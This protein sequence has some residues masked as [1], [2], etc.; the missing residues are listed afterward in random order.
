MWILLENLVER[1]SRMDRRRK[2]PRNGC[3]MSLYYT[4][5]LGAVQ[6]QIN[7][8]LHWLPC[9]RHNKVVMLPSAICS[10]GW[11][12]VIWAIPC[13]VAMGSWIVISWRRVSGT[14]APSGLPRTTGWVFSLQPEWHGLPAR[15]ISFRGLVTRFLSWRCEPLGVRSVTM[16]LYRLPVSCICKN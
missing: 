8:R 16:G 12:S 3:I 11:N 15:K 9:S 7:T 2:V 1:W 4:R 10:V 13:V 5:Q 14:T 6:K